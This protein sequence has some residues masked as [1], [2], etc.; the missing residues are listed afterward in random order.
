MQLEEIVPE[1]HSKNVFVRSL[2]LKRLKIAI[3]LARSELNS[4]N[5]L[6]V[7]DLGCGE[8][9]LLKL[10]EKEFKDIRTIGIDVKTDV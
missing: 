8:G 3:Q 4:N 6:K 1:Y 9:V 10:L 2:F 5:N 7:I